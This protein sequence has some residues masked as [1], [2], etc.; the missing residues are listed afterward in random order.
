[1]TDETDA[2]DAVTDAT[3]VPD[4]EA[5][6]SQSDQIETTPLDAIERAF[7]AVD[8]HDAQTVDDIG[9]KAADPEGN[10]AKATERGCSSDG[11]LEALDAEADTDDNADTDAQDADAAE[12]IGEPPNRFSTDA[13]AAWKD[14]PQPVRDEVSRLER[15]LSAGL[16]KYRGDAERFE[17]FRHFSDALDERGQNFQDVLSHYL[18]IEQLLAQDPLAGFEQIAQNMGADFATVAAQYLDRSPDEVSATQD[19]EMNALRM[20]VSELQQQLGGVTTSI[21]DQRT[22]QAMNEIGAFKT[23]RPRFDELSND[24]ALLIQTGRAKD[25]Q[26]AYELAERLNPAPAASH[27]AITAAQTGKDRAAQTR[28]KT[29]LSVDGGPGSGSN[30]AKRQPP[31]TAEDAV[32]NAFAALG[33]G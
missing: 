26:S 14:A 31:K 30:P 24:M 16:E 27:N 5:P 28:D 1:M 15:E 32:E 10:Q 11:M 18:G 8:R 19:A 3:F 2:A 21:A 9:N 23:G 33:I 7:A 12:N 29:K 25:L 20:Q 4:I 13:K 17:E 22:Q 6:I